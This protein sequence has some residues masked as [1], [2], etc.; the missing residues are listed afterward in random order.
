MCIESDQPGRAL[1]EGWK[2]G[3][4]MQFWVGPW[5]LI[6]HITCV[7]VQKNW[8][9]IVGNFNFKW[10]SQDPCTVKIEPHSITVEGFSHWRKPEIRDRVCVVAGEGGNFVCQG[11]IWWWGKRKSS[12]GKNVCRGEGLKE[13]KEGGSNSWR[14]GGIFYWD[15]LHSVWMRMDGKDCR[16]VAWGFRWGEG[17]GNLLTDYT[18]C[19]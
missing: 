7:Q 4:K 10:T 17:I 8:E 15:R 14:H 18:E 11:V 9:E 3:T 2:E 6:R 16:W 5:N 13:N 1:G 19:G 12:A